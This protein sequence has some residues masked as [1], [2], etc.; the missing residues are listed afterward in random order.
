MNK[1]IFLFLPFFFFPK[2]VMAGLDRFSYLDRVE[3]WIIERKIDSLSKEVFCRASVS[4]YG[5][6]FDTRI[7]LDKNDKLVFPYNFSKKLFPKNSTIKSVRRSLEICR[8]SL[9]Y[10]PSVIEK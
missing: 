1:Y 7:R 8:S 3:D 2:G 4:K 9:I 10:I 6:W 5:G